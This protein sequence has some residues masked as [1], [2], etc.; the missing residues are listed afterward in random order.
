MFVDLPTS[1]LLAICGFACGCVMGGVARGARF[2]TFGAIEDYVLVGRTL[3]L[4][5]W[6]LAIAVATLLVSAMHGAGIARLDEVF[7]LAPQ[8]GWAGAIIGGLMFGFGMAMVGTCGYGV[9][10]RMGGGDMKAVVSFLVMG[11]TAYMTARGLTGVA[12]VGIIEPLASDLSVYGGQGLPHVLSPLLGINAEKLWLPV[13]ACIAAVL[14]AWCFWSKE[15][16]ASRRDVIA[17]ALIGLVIA[18]GFAATGI[19]GADV[20]DP[21]PVVSM[22]YVLPP[23]ETIV[24]LLT[25][26][27]ATLTFG[28][29]TILGTLAGAFSVA[30]IKREIV[31]EAYDG[32]R[33]MSRHLIGAAMMGIGGVTAL[34]CT[35]GQGITGISTLSLSAPIA[36]AAILVGGI[37]GVHYLLNGSVLEALRAQFQLDG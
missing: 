5:A 4:R 12:R 31:V 28:I 22:T 37:F 10:V 7:Y 23:G 36:L 8:F 13:G 27:G 1:S 34:G 32:R 6:A 19:L 14:S 33:E 11:L 2:C 20:F 30:L 35:V 17:G 24:Y 18:A 21:K 26:S 16:R 29:G 3:R 25:F 15:F 9:L